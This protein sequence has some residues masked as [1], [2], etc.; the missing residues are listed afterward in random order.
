M[1]DT[2]QSFTKR[3]RHLVEVIFFGFALVV[4]WKLYLNYLD[5]PRPKPKQKKLQF[6]GGRL[7]DYV[8]VSNLPPRSF[9]YPD[10][11]SLASY[12]QAGGGRINRW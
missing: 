5:K 11:K 1:A 9:G 8:D 7:S 2:I 3:N 6:D 4:A 12:P 10:P